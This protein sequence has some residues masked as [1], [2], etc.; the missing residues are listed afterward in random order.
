VKEL[1]EIG[2]RCDF[3]T[4]GSMYFWNSELKIEFIVPEK[5]RGAAGIVHIRELGLKAIPLRFVN[6]LLDNPIFI[7]EDNMEILLPNPVNFCLHKLLIA[8]R[9]KSLDK[10]LKDIEQA[11]YTSAMIS[12]YVVSKLFDSLPKS[13]RQKILITLEHAR[14]ELPLLR[15]ESERLLL[16]LQ[17]DEKQ[18]K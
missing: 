1:E 12:D 3:N 8:S 2:F 15:N 5:G 18:M 13:W 7:S 16:V 10:N 4:D 6:L 14:T 17:E 11:L 9:R